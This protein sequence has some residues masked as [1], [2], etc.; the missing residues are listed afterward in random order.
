MR[1]PRLHQGFSHQGYTPHPAIAQHLESLLR[2]RA[3]HLEQLCST[4]F[5]LQAGEYVDHLALGDHGPGTDVVVVSRLACP[6]SCPFTHT[7][8]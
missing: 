6:P 4:A 3:E 8:R 5:L 1:D 2:A 7:I